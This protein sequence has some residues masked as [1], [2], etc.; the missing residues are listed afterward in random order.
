[1]MVAMMIHFPMS[2]ML[3]LVGAWLVHKLDWGGALM[4]G[5][6]FGIVLYV[7][8]FYFI[9]P[10]AFPWFT[11]ARNWVSAFAHAMFGAV[12]GMAYVGLRKPRVDRG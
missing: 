10:A 3:G 2:I 5:A 1:M 8:N 7:V 9:A 6:I 12:I 11:M 4:V